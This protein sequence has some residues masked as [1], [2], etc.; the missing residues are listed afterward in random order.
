MCLTIPNTNSSSIEFFR[1]QPSPV[2]LLTWAAP[3]SPRQDCLPRELSGKLDI[4]SRAYL[5]ETRLIA[6]FNHAN[7]I[8][9]P[10]G[11]E[12]GP[13]SGHH[14][15]QQQGAV[16]HTCPLS[17]ELPLNESHFN[18][19]SVCCWE[20]GIENSLMVW[21]EKATSRDQHEVLGTFGTR[22]MLNW[23]DEWVASWP[24]GLMDSSQKST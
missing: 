22:W 14:R 12:L 7:E 20:G 16:R 24:A 13:E 9:G 2:I 19:K 18:F 21:S 23:L 17:A 8:H 11:D 6:L 15:I 4:W 3:P 1:G 5:G 10:R